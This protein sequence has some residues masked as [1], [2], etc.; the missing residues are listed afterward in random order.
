MT[1]TY[2]RAIH[3]FRRD[4]RL[5]DNSA[6]HAAVAAAGEV[7]TAYVVSPWKGSHA[8]TGPPRQAFLASCLAA[9]EGEA[10]VGG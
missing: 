10:K 1:P 7:V 4:L 3:W 9:L 8:W 5:T 6:L 2:A